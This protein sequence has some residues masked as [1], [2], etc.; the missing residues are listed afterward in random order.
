MINT[1]EAAKIAREAL[2]DKKGEDIKVLDIKGLS[3]IADCFV[4][5]SGNNPNQLRAMADEVEE[6]LFKEG[7]KL[8]HSEGYTGG[9]WILLD[10]GNLL[11][12]LFN[13]SEREFYSLDR[14][15]GD[16]KEM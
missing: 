1:L 3:N 5:A 9:T 2:E 12:H 16:A 7:Y 11:I 13:K 8:H 14:V 10:F 6:K 15:W 4:I